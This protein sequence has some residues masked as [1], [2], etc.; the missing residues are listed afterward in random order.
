MIKA[1]CG[2]ARAADWTDSVDYTACQTLAAM[3]RDA[4]AQAI[5]VRSARDPGGINVVLLDPGCF[6]KS[7]PAHGSNWHVRLEGDRLSAF[8]AFPGDEVLRFTPEQFGLP[9][10]S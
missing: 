6:A 3:A 9:E 5:R 1:R 10:L 8:A 2:L 4:G 7:E